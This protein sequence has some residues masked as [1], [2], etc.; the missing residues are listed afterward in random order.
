VLD[1]PA[2][3]HA[4]DEHEPEA[5][6]AVQVRCAQARIALRAGVA[7]LDAHGTLVQADPQVD[8]AVLVHAPVTHAV[9][10][11]LGHQQLQVAEPMARE[12]RVKPLRQFA[13]RVPCCTTASG[14]GDAEVVAHRGRRKY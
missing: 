8:L 3:R 9:R 1:A 14:E 7:Q 5:A 10:H 6:A 4:L 2:L 11:D 13:P 12:V